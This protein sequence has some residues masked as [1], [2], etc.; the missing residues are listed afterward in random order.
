MMLEIS[1]DQRETGQE[2]GSALGARVM[3][4]IWIFINFGLFVS[5]PDN[6]P[7]V[8]LLFVVPFYTWYGL[9]QAFANDRL[10]AQLEADPAMAKT[11]H[12]KVQPCSPGWAQRSP[13]LALPA[14]HRVSGGHHRHR[15]PDGLVDHAE[16][17]A[18]RAGESDPD[19]EPVEGAVVLPRP[20]GDAG[21]LR[22]RGSPAW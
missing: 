20:A 2:A 10:I 22:S 9:R 6:V 16:R 1:E 13:R 4:L 7:I 19:D 5:T 8:L 18:R 14:A 12:R 21:V 17:A 15:H 3:R 11:H